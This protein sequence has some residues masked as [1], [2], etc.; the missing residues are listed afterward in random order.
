M[1]N[2]LDVDPISLVD[3][4]VESKQV[5]TPT[6]ALLPARNYYFKVYGKH[7]I[8]IPRKGSYYELA[9]DFFSESDGEFN[10]LDEKNAVMYLPA[11]SKVLFATA[12]YPDLKEGEL[13][14]PIALKFNE[15]TV[16]IY[17]QIISMLAPTGGDQL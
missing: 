14:A 8:T 10:L 1:V 4:A 7:K 5:G 12:Q 3:W 2:R 15:S 11:I 17:G 9:P 6:I 13:F 16:D